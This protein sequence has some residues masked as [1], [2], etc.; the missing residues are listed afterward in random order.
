MRKLTSKFK[1]Q[2]IFM[3][4]KQ[5]NLGSLKEKLKDLYMKVLNFY[6]RRPSRW[7]PFKFLSFL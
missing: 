2:F 1:A 5:T 3:N 6:A 7:R 4:E